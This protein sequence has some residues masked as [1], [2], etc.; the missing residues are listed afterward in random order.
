M[1]KTVLSLTLFA[2]TLFLGA[3]RAGAEAPPAIPALTTDE[4]A[5][6]KRYDRNGD[7]KLDEDELAAA[8]EALLKESFSSR[9]AGVKGGRQRAALI[10]RFDKNG[11]G[12]LDATDW[13]EAKRVIL[14]RYDT[15]HDGRLDEDERAAMRADFKARAQALKL[16]N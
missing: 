10:R 9:A 14:A 8:H 13:A 2:A 3:A 15:N 6:L 16:K 12:K 1:K 4:Q 11:D 7:G 5:L